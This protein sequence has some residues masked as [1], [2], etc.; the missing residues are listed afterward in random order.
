MNLDISHLTFISPTPS[1]TRCLS[2]HEK[3]DLSFLGLRR[4][5]KLP[6]HIKSYFELH[7]VL[8]LQLAKAAG[9][10]LVRSNDPINYQGTAQNGHEAGI[11]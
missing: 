9:Q 11:G 4:S 1:I 10:I 5:H 2:L 3:S 6:D 7:V 8:F